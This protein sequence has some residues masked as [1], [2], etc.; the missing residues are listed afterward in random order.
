MK[1]QNGFSK[2]MLL[3]LLP[4]TLWG[5]A[6]SSEFQTVPQEGANRTGVFPRFSQKP[7]GVTQQFTEEERQHLTGQLDRD[8]RNLRGVAQAKPA[9]PQDSARLREDAKREAEETLRQ[10]EQSGQ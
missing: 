8:A 3:V 6:A 10:I 7:H 2:S 1:K 4:V 9:S 5:C